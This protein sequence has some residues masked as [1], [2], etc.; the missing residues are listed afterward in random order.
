MT[1]E[2]TN[3]T[4]RDKFFKALDTTQFNVC[5]D[6]LNQWR[7]WLTGL[8]STKAPY[9]DRD[10]RH[11]LAIL[12]FERREFDQAEHHWLELLTEDLSSLQ[13]ARILLELGAT[14][15]EQA[16]FYQAE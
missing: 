12:H 14:L 11:C 6:V 2:I 13:R 7:W 15:C 8:T 5:E 3:Q 4:F 16:Q 9:F 1:E 10:R